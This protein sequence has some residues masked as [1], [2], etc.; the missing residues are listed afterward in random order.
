M[1]STKETLARLPPN[2]GKNNNA[3]DS[4]HPIGS[5]LAR[6][7]P[8]LSAEAN[9]RVGIQ[10]SI[11]RLG[12]GVDISDKPAEHLL[13]VLNHLWCPSKAFDPPCLKFWRKLNTHTGGEF[14]EYFVE[15][16]GV[17]MRLGKVSILISQAKF[18]R[19][20]LEATE[21]HSKVVLL[22]RAPDEWRY[23][24]RCLLKVSELLEGGRPCPIMTR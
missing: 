1:E 24:V 9:I 6:Q 17:L 8:E 18:S 22:R 5:I 15:D 7:W 10:V 23:I 14:F 2:E 12:S 20:L 21:H 4:M 13:A 3:T 11:M 16:G 19:A